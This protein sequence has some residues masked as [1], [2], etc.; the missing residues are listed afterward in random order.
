MTLIVGDYRPAKSGTENIPYNTRHGNG[1]FLHQKPSPDY[2][3][4]I[5]YYRCKDNSS[6]FNLFNVQEQALY[7]ILQPAFSVSRRAL[8]HIRQI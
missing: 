4:G 7:C 1:A 5:I 8:M 3:A 6:C 2:T